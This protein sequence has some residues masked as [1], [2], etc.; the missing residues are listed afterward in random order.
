VNH[1]DE[2]DFEKKETRNVLKAL[3]EYGLQPHRFTR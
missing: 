3:R 1:L 2:E